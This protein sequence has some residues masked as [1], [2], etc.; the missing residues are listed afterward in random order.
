M[1]NDLILAMPMIPLHPEDNCPAST[2]LK[3]QGIAE[4]DRQDDGETKSPFA[5]L[6]ELKRSDR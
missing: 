3:D 5:K 6:A 1:E 2:L 4:K